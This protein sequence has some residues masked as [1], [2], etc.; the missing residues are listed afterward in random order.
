V[1]TLILGQAIIHKLV[2]VSR[3]HATA[4]ERENAEEQEINKWTSTTILVTPHLHV[5]AIQNTM[6]AK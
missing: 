4:R 6:S 5:R 1:I 3:M 2:N